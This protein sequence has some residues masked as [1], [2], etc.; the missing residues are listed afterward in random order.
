MTRIK[1]H[2]GDILII[3]MIIWAIA[4]LI[5]NWNDYSSCE[6]PIIQYVIVSMLL[7]VCIRIYQLISFAMS[8]EEVQE[9]F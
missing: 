7:I 9:P 1:F 6:H 3:L 4:D 2:F 5:R 8:Y